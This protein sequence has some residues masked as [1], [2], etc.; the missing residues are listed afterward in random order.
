MDREVLVYADLEGRPL[1]VGRLWARTRRGRE[2]ATFEYDKDWLMRPSRFSLEPALT[3]DPGPF[4][5]PAGKPLFGAMGDSAPD[6]W[7]RVLMRRAE[8]RRAKHA[9][10]TPRTLQPHRPV[11]RHKPARRL[12]P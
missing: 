2:G 9:G 10:E 11:L 12:P 6:R 1:L 5:T 7:G 3:L 4:H 8:R